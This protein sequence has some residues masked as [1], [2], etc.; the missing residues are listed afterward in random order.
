[1]QAVRRK[2]KRSRETILRR[3]QAALL[4]N[5]LDPSEEVSLTLFPLSPI[6]CTI[7]QGRGLQ[8]KAKPYLHQI[9][10]LLPVWLCDLRR[11][12]TDTGRLGGERLGRAKK[13]AGRVMPWKYWRCKLFNTHIRDYDKVFKI[14]KVYFF[15]TWMDACHLSTW[16]VH[17]IKKYYL[18][19]VSFF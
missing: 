13:L 9:V 3:S 12:C 18:L 8:T 10:L 11:P 14:E 1:M 2:W 4:L 17:R 15:N 19:K 6:A 16:I 7:L 5:S